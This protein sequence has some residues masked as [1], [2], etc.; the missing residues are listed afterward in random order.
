MTRSMLESERV[1]RSV[2][3]GC[4]RS[5]LSAPHNRW[6]QAGLGILALGVLTLM[7][8]PLGIM[9]WKACSNFLFEKESHSIFFQPLEDWTRY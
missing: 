2:C 3:P 7:L 1:A 6:I 9:A 8:A 5:I 4:G